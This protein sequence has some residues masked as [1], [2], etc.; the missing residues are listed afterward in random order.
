V[1]KLK[2]GFM[3]EYTNAFVIPEGLKFEY[4]NDGIVIS[5]KDDI[6]L[7]GELGSTIQRITSLE[8]DVYIELPLT[9]Q[10]IS[11]PNGTIYVRK[12]LNV[13]KVEGK[14]IIGNANISVS[15]ILTTH[16]DFHL[17]ASFQSPKIH[18]KGNCTITGNT[19]IDNCAIEGN[20]IFK[21][22]YNGKHLHVDGNLSI[23]GQT[24]CQNIHALGTS[25]QC[26]S[27]IEANE[28]IG[29]RANIIIDG[30]STI[31][32][33]RSNKAVI[34]GS[35][36]NI[37][38]MQINTH[39]DIAKCIIFS[40][41]LMCNSIKIHPKSTGKIMVLESQEQMGP[42]S[43]KGCLQLSDLEGLIPNI[44]DFLTQRGLHKQA[45]L[46]EDS[47]SKGSITIPEVEPEQ[48]IIDDEDDEQPEEQ[49][50]SPAVINVHSA[51]SENNSE[52][53]PEEESS[54]EE[55]SEDENESSSNSEKAVIVIEEDDSDEEIGIDGKIDEE[56]MLSELTE[57]T[58]E[59]VLVP[60]DA[61]VPLHAEI[62]MEIMNVVN[63]YQDTP[64]SAVSELLSLMEKGD[65]FVLREE[66]KK[67]WTKL[68]KYHQRQNTRLPPKVIDSFNQ[69]NAKL[70]LL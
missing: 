44:E 17:E 47:G 53:Q 5:H 18:C 12:P 64:P 58:E 41:I 20:A 39:I 48:N 35:N 67:I 27:L 28:I 65:F 59:E 51:I 22:T 43:V 60:E 26:K 68:L 9:T 46:P 55:S 40:D 21:G 57:Y 33:L 10:E 63:E 4:T 54:S 11:A 15:E 52:P 38:A 23:D 66:I 45:P 34:N 8:G 70:A 3:A 30:D 56:E 69:L 13:S 16:A 61:E 32:L 6:V 25:L 1:H 62:K 49:S 19:T 37:K 29:D 36:N 31:K 50:P 14:N 2:E 7:R 42:H 24:I